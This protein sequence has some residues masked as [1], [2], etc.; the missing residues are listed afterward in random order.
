MSAV[1]PDQ[2]PGSVA[3]TRVG[4]T[5]L[6]SQSLVILGL[7]TVAASIVFFAGTIVGDHGGRSLVLVPLAIGVSLIL[8]GLTTGT[9][10]QKASF[11][12]SVAMVGQTLSLQLINA[13]YQLRYQHY[14]P[15]GELLLYPNVLFLAGALVQ[16]LLVGIAL[17][18]V[19]PA[20]ANWVRT[21]MR[22]W[23]LVVLALCF[24]LPTTT[25]SPER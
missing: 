17:R 24:F 1:S 19:V 25:V 13:G 5:R 20:I 3:L 18:G 4:H 21:R 23:Q 2:L 15:L 12:F 8:A 7:V 11:W 10:W 14:K 22:I 6:V 16:L 9:A